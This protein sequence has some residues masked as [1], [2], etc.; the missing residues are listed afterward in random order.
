MPQEADMCPPVDGVLRGEDKERIGQRI[1]GAGNRDTMLL[2]SL[3][4][5]SLSLRRRTVDFV[6]KNN[7]GKDR[8]LNELEVTL[9]IENFR[10]RD[11]GRHKVWGEL[12]ARE[13]KA[14][15]LSQGIHHQS[16]GQP[17]NTEK[18]AMPPCKDRE[19]ET[20]NGFLLTHNH[21]GHF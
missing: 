21:F 5:C 6:G 9:T 16:L 4:E 14:E 12:D 19:E 15:R 10:T 2:H 20:V 13:R 3:E 11:I 18:Q 7:T 1:G 8:T 17:R